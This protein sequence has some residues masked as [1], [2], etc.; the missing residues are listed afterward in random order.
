VRDEWRQLPRDAAIA[1]RS[2]R[3]FTGYSNMLFAVK[4]K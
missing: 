4:H 1:G 3:D 2:A